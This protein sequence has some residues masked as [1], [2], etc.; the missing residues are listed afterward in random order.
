MALSF[1]PDVAAPGRGRPIDWD[2]RQAIADAA[3][4]RFVQR[5]FDGLSLEAVAADAGVSKVTIYRAFGDRSGLLAAVVEVESV[6]M[7]QALE[8]LSLSEAPLREQ[9]L[10]LALQL[11]KHLARPEVQAFERAIVAEGARHPQLLQRF[12]DAGPGRIRGVIA[13]LLHK[14]G[15]ATDMA[16]TLAEELMAAWSGALPLE[17][18][19][20]MAK[21]PRTAQLRARLQAID[22]RFGSAL[23]PR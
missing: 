6:R 16:R 5:G 8:A 9:L 20:G 11:L 13:A 2:K 14:Q 10:E 22:A 18:R 7:E 1:A 23:D 19:F 4:E 21:P 15:W 3:R 12:F 17:T